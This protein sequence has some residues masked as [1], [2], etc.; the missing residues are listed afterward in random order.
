MLDNVLLGVAEFGGPARSINPWVG[1]FHGNSDL[2]KVH[3][4][5]LCGSCNNDSFQLPVSARNG[6][7]VKNAL[8]HCS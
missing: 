6:K 3:A 2:A 5:L 1:F 8:D 4:V 7:S